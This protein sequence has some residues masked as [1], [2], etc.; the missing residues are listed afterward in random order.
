[1]NK[2]IQYK[3]QATDMN[4]TPSAASSP[5]QINEPDKRS[6]NNALHNSVLLEAESDYVGTPL[7]KPHWKVEM[8]KHKPTNIIDINNI[9][10]SQL[11][12]T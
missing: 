1:M 3:E 10:Q 5:I 7:I 2:K 11:E 8:K 9:P 6:E 4:T 12:T